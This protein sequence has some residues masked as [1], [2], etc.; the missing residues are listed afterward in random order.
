MQGIDFMRDGVT[1]RGYRYWSLYY[2][3]TLNTGNCGTFCWMQD[4]WDDI[5]DAIGAPAA[6]GTGSGS[7]TDAQP[8]GALRLGGG[9]GLLVP[10]CTAPRQGHSRLP[11]WTTLALW[12]LSNPRPVLHCPAPPCRRHHLRP[13]EEL[14]PVQRRLDALRRVSGGLV[15][16]LLPRSCA[17]CQPAPVRPACNPWFTAAQWQGHAHAE[18]GLTGS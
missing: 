4:Q 15:G 8:N 5:P 11:C 18:W 3:I 17:A 2:S 1:V 14:G 6:G 9:S 10:C 12:Q 7:C 16:G 13:E